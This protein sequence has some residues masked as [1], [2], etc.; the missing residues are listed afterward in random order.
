MRS[1]QR[2]QLCNNRSLVMCTPA[3]KAPGEGSEGGREE[4]TPTR[5]GAH[6]C[7]RE[8]LLRAAREAVLTAQLDDWLQSLGGPLPK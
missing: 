3:A 7:E 6:T 2:I 5:S 8:A 4:Y 1:T